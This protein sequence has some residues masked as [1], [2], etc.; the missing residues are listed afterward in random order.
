MNG[1]FVDPF[2]GGSCAA[3]EAAGTI[4][5]KMDN[6]EEKSVDPSKVD[7][8]AGNE[9]GIT[10]SDHCALINMNEPCVLENSRLRFLDDAIYTLVGTIMIAINPFARIDIYGPE[11]MK[12]YVGKQLGAHGVEA[13]LYGMGEAAYREMMRSKKPTALVMSGESG[14]GKT[15]TAKHLMNYIAWCSEQAD[16]SS[17][18]LAGKLANMIIASSPLLEAFGNAKT[19]RNNNSSR[20][21]KMM[22]LH[23]HPNGAMAGAY[24]KTYLLEKIRVVAITSPER[25]Y[26]GLLPALQQRFATQ[27][28]APRVRATRAPCRSHIR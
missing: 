3:V 14:S 20:F 8:L 16:A 21:G 2:I 26:H 12:K 7:V 5:L 27:P 1:L 9:T 23:F 19:V 15:E 11:R 6:G 18:G 28:L 24:I 4:K 25:N 13:H 22:R 17:A 10:A